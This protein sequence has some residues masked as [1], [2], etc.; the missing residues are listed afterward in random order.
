MISGETLL[1]TLHIS[2]A[3]HCKYLMWADTCSNTGAFENLVSYFNRLS[4]IMVFLNIRLS[5]SDICFGTSIRMRSN[6]LWRSESYI[7]I[8][9]YISYYIY[10]YIYI[11]K[12]KF[13]TH[14]VLNQHNKER[15]VIHIKWSHE[16]NPMCPSSSSPQWLWVLKQSA[17]QALGKEHKYINSNRHCFMK[18][19][20]LK[21]H[22]ARSVIHIKWSHEDNPMHPSSSSPQWLSGNMP[23]IILTLSSNVFKISGKKNETLSRF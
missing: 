13:M 18:H 10:I 9:I 5:Y 4:S 19:R 21:K 6:K 17:Q 16:D 12:Q 2:V 11:L 1:F 7:Y 22:K 15:S 23:A 8:Y 14:R 20:L 3:E